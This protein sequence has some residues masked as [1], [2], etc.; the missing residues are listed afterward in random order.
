MRQI[1]G[2]LL[3]LLLL[4]LLLVGTLHVQ[5]DLRAMHISNHCYKS[6]YIPPPH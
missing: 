6:L 2:W 4:L 3:L 5:G 1:Y